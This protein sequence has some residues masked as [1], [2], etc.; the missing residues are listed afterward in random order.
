MPF[1][2]PARYTTEGAAHKPSCIQLSHGHE[3]ARLPTS[4]NRK[5]IIES[6]HVSK[7][8]RRPEAQVLA[9]PSS[10]AAAPPPENACT[11]EAACVAQHHCACR[12]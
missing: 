12:Q 10:S 2:G 3:P 8:R 11:L 4:K 9:I 6:P 5:H 1:L 7:P